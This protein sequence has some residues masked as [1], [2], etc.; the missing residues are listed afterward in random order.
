MENP[1]ENLERKYWEGMEKHDYNVV[2]NLTYFP[3]ITAGKDGVRNV[4]EPT[5]K[6]MFESG[7]NVQWN[8][9]DISEIQTHTF[10]DSATITYQIELE[11]IH[12]GK[13]T[14]LKCACTSTWI[15]ENG[16]WLCAMHTESDLKS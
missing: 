5:Y 11:S 16:K 8:V 9:L 6:S 3:C 1:I 14:P 2:R 7:K 4:D 10:G 13:K 12:E 15:K